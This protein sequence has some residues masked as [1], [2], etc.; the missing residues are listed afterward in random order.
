[1]SR[2]HE[3]LKRAEQERALRGGRVETEAAVDTPALQAPA[4]TV[5]SPSANTS[6]GQSAGTPLARVYSS[7]RACAQRAQDSA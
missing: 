3:A 7:Q 4:V 5:N 6:A 2:I 1:M